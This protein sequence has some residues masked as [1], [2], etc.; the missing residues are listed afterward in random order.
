KGI[1]KSK[2]ICDHHIEAGLGRDSVGW[3]IQIS[4]LEA[5]LMS[6]HH[7]REGL[8]VAVCQ[9]TFLFPQNIEELPEFI[10]TLK[11]L[12]YLIE[13]NQ[14]EANKLIGIYNKIYISYYPSLNEEPSTSTSTS[15][16][17]R[18]YNSNMTTSPT[19]YTPP[20]GH[21]NKSVIPHQLFCKEKRRLF[22]ERV[23]IGEDSPEEVILETKGAECMFGWIEMVDNTWYNSVTG[24]KSDVSPCQ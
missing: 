9:Y 17:H 14:V 13:R 4:G 10:H 8:F 22:H 11:G 21:R 15:T 2:D 24:E 7:F 18:S 23:I 5:R 12:E 6:I 16:C 3:G 20:S 19:Y 1:R